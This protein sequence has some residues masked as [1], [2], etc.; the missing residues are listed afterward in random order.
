ME[1]NYSSGNSQVLWSDPKSAVFMLYG[2][3]DVL[4]VEAECALISRFLAPEY[5]DFDLEVL[6]TDGSTAESIL[7][8]ASQMPFGSERRVVLV[9][10]MEQWRDRGRAAEAEKLATGIAK[11]TPPACLILVVASEEDESKRK[12]AV[13]PKLDNA[14]KQWGVFAAC[15]SLKDEP[16]SDWI[17][18]RVKFFGK[19]I[20]R[21]AVELLISGAGHEMRALNHEIFKLINYIGDRVP[22]T[23][24]DVNLVVAEQAEDVIFQ[25]VDAISKRQTDRALTLLNE[26]HREEPKPHAVAAKLMGLLVRQYRLLYQAKHLGNQ[27]ITARN[28]KQLPENLSAQLPADPAISAAYRASDLLILAQKYTVNELQW[29]FERLLMCDLANKGGVTEEDS[30]FSLEP[31]ANLQLL[32]MQLTAV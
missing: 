25:C 27:G 10:G 1:V 9:K 32:V 18:E 24:R 26:L 20:D 23:V 2:D 5:S 29:I 6:N 22:I 3:E 30:Q 13:V 28:I 14:V 17:I 21:D 31:V 12:T 19:R 8:A 11:L 16:L 4:K 15:R 7:G